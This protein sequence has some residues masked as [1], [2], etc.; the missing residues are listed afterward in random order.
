[1]RKVSPVVKLCMYMS[2]LKTNGNDDIKNYT[3]NYM[4]H[5]FERIK[6]GD[7]E[8]MSKKILGTIEKIKIEAGMNISIRMLNQV[9]L[10]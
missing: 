1:M 7:D 6:T 8:Y 5:G 3:L 4:I 9:T 10:F 2:M